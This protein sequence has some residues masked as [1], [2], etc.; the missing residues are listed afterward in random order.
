MFSAVK[1]PTRCRLATSFRKLDGP[2][3]QQSHS[4]SKAIKRAG[5]KDVSPHVARHTVATRLLEAG[6]NVQEVQYILG[7]A[8]P[9]TTM[10]YL[11][12][13]TQLS[14][15]RAAE[16]LNTKKKPMLASVK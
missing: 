15:K 7:H 1:R 4:I 11:H 12:A 9:Q 6:M 14:A 5:L 10:R 8:D 16:I 13:S 3:T 2:R